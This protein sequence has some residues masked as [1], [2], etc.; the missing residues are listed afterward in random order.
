MPAKPKAGRF[1]SQ[2]QRT[3]ACAGV[4]MRRGSASGPTQV[5]GAASESSLHLVQR[6]AGA[7]KLRRV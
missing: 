6:S 3:F 2:A 5:P 4:P 7:V 1:I